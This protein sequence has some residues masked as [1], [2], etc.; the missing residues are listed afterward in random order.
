M[1]NA[2]AQRDYDKQ[3][4]EIV[5]MNVMALNKEIEEKG[6]G[7]NDTSTLI[8]GQTIETTT[9]SHEWWYN[10]RTKEG[11]RVV[12]GKTIKGNSKIMSKEAKVRKERENNKDIGR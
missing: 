3:G 10:P 8:P 7:R 5:F 11:I 2:G 4:L 6:N 12:K 1:G 9:H